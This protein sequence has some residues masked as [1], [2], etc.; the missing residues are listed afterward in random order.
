MKLSTFC[1]LFSWQICTFLSFPWICGSKNT[2]QPST[3]LLWSL[4][5]LDLLGIVAVSFHKR[6]EI[7]RDKV[8]TRY[9]RDCCTVV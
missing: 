8:R 9:F 7:V 5:Q 4:F 1:P 3:T 6:E 2:G